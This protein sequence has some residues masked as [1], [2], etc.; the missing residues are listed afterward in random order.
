MSDVSRLNPH[1]TDD[2]EAFAMME[3]LSRTLQGLRALSDRNLTALQFYGMELDRADTDI[4]LL[5]ARA[6]GRRSMA[7]LCGMFGRSS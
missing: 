2:D 1:M 7:Q 5:K 3:T 4:A 6:S